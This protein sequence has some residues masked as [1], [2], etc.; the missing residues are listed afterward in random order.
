MSKREDLPSYFGTRHRAASGLSELTDALVVVVS[1]ERGEITLFKENT[2]HPIQSASELEKLLQEHAGDDSPK[3]RFKHQT[4]ELVTVGLI[5]LFCITGVWANF[6]K[7]ME[8]LT[9]YE[10]PVEFINPDQKM[11]IISS[12]ASN[13]KLL[14]SGAKPLIKAI[15]PEQINIKLNL[16][17]SVVGINKLSITKEN[18]L[19]P[20][21]IRLKKI[22]PSKLE[23]KLDTIIEKELFIQPDW[24]GKLPKG[25]I[26]TNA[27]PKPAKILVAGGALALKNINTIF[28]EKIDLN[29]LTKSGIVTAALVLDTPPIKLKGDHKVQIQ[30]LISK[31]SDQ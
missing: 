13:I 4:V 27:T 8:T 10:V 14:I 21:G 7:G 3:K 29:K 24:T 25:L 18:I 12:S 22:E 28:T 20:P 16:A 19:L 5:S 17:D 15:K 9:E 26:M 11:E 23:I 6:T 30:Y 1:E 31:K 2:H